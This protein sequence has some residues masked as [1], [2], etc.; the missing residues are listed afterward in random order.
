MLLLKGVGAIAVAGY[1][2][3]LQLSEPEPARE[4][5]VPRDEPPFN[6][7]AEEWAAYEFLGDTADDQSVGVIHRVG[8]EA[9]DHLWTIDWPENPDS[10][11][12]LLTYRNWTDRAALDLTNA[13]ASVRL[14]GDLDLAGGYIRFW[15]LADGTRWH[16]DKRIP[17][18][19]TVSLS[20]AADGPWHRSWTRPLREPTPVSQVLAAVESYGFAIV[21]FEREATGTLRLERLQ[22]GAP[23][24]P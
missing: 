15:V 16:L 20:L 2:V 18:D 14:S 21:D 13:T 1:L 5:P 4:V 3:A 7:L 6:A 10:I 24:Q 17:L 11:L 23:T 19:Q 8:S 22:F 9:S 12:C